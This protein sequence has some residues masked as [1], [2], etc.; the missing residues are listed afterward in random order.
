MRLP[1]LLASVIVF[2]ALCPSIALAQSA[3]AGQVRD[4]TGAVLPGA[5]VEAASPALIEGRREVTTDG[6]GRYSIVDLRP[7]IYTVTFRLQGFTTVVRQG[8]DLPSNFTATVDASLNV[9]S[10][11]ETVTVTGD[12]PLVDVRQTTRSQV[13]S[14]EELD[15]LVT[16]RTTWSQAVLLAGVQMTGTDVG[17]S[18]AAV[19]LLL[20]THGANARHSTYNIDGMQVNT[21]LGEG[22][23]QNYYQD[24]S[25]QEVA[26]QT[27]G[28]NAEVSAGGVYLNMIPKDGGNKFAGTLYVG[29][30]DGS[31]MADNFTQELK[32]KGIQAIN[33]ITGIFDYG[34]TQGG[35]ILKDRLWFHISG[36]Y[37]GVNQFVPDSFLD[38]GSQYV[39]E[40]SIFAMTPRLTY[41]ATRNNKFRVHLDRQSKIRGPKLQAR[42]PAIINGLGADPETATTW[43]NWRIPYGVFQSKWTSTVTNRLLLEAGYSSSFTLHPS[44]E[45]QAGVVAPNGTPE[46][47]THVR[48]ND[49]DR[50]VQWDGVTA[51]F[52]RWPYRHVLSGAVSYVTGTH[53]LK[54][55]VQQNWGSDVTHTDVNGHISTMQYR[56]GVPDAATVTNYP[57]RIEPHQKADLGMFAQDSWTTDRL[58]LN[59]GL[60]LEWQNSY[61]PEQFAPAGRFVGERHFAAV[62][63]VPK[64]G[65][66]LSPRFGVAF[67][68]FGDAKTALKFSIGKYMT[69]Q[70]VE[71]ATD[72]NPMAAA[73]ISLPWN[74]RDLQ[75]RSLPT[76]GDNIAQDNELDLTRLPTN[77]G[78]RQLDR[79]DPD[80]KREYNIETALS[81]Q[82][83]LTPRVSVAAGWYRRSFHNM[84][85]RCYGPS[86]VAQGQGYDNLRCSDNLERDFNDYV[87]VQIVSPYNGEIITAYNL[88][89][90]SELSKVD[91]VLTNAKGNQESYNG[92]ELG[93]EA[94]LPGGGTML[95]STVFQRS[96][97]NYCDQRDD[98]NELRFCDRFHL[99]APYKGVDFKTDFKLAGSYPTPFFGLQASG[100]FRSTPGRTFAD[101]S[102]VDEL[103]AINWNI[104]RTTRYTAEGCAGRPCT[105]GAL[106]IPGL[107]QTS[108]VVPL[109]PAGTERKLSRL[110]QLDL[111]VARKFR[112]RG[113]ELTGQVQV[114]NVLNASTVVTERSSNFGTPTYGLPNEILLGRVPRIS[115]QM[116]W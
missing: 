80:M 100:T 48:K 16:S 105:P 62:E 4:N 108:L 76:N 10:L 46:W 17:G 116:K 94:R 114:Y 33:R 50:N 3:I 92:F 2:L 101:F 21:M 112:A 43:Q 103:L 107:V 85:L 71:Y 68:L 97:T 28:G 49:I 42:Y 65:P 45:P 20:E 18:R 37:W 70:G 84:V 14:R 87:P 106:V 47:L 13:L 75:G 44:G 60:R 90:V 113:V 56:S 57:L 99:P 52:A 104:S 63:D 53:N 74:D 9:G 24:Q 111:G 19:D 95:G 29:G 66:D 58:T 77:F 64:W 67:D 82:H 12:S 22:S 59:G 34:A 86:Y 8:I 31:W 25:N 110:T 51:W 109:A 91:N 39:V 32:D 96:R 27:S 23:Q 35:P 98:P 93:L 11:T 89:D 115:L 54:V 78:E 69:R 38:D 73:T 88:R 36:R 5:T 83:S 6:Q 72:L 55:G 61:V 15:T 1:A 30:S 79:L 40:G 7:G 26:I 102:R 81:V 41:Q